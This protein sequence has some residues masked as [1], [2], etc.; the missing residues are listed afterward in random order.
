MSRSSFHLLL[1]LLFF[2]ARFTAWAQSPDTQQAQLRERTLLATN[3]ARAHAASGNWAEAISTLQNAINSLS[4]SNS[5]TAA[6]RHYLYF[7]MGY[8]YEHQPDADAATL[9]LAAQAYA[10]ALSNKPDDVKTLNNLI[11]VSRAIGDNLSALTY[12]DHIIRLDSSSAYQWHLVA[13]DIYRSEGRQD[14]AWKEYKKAIDLNPTNRTAAQ[15]IVD[16]YETGPADDQKLLEQCKEFRQSGM[17]EMARIGLEEILRKNCDTWSSDPQY[18]EDALLEWAGVLIENRW[19]RRDIFDGI[20]AMKC[21]SR[22]LEDLQRS[23]RDGWYKVGFAPSQ[24]SWWLENERRAFYYLAMQKSWADYLLTTGRQREAMEL[25]E[26]AWAPLNRIQD[27]SREIYGRNGVVLIDLLTQLARVYTNKTLDP[28]GMKFREMESRLFEQKGAAISADDLPA[29]EKF[30]TILGYI[31][32][33]RKQW[34]NGARGAKFQLEHAIRAAKMAA[35][36]DPT[37]SKPIPHLYHYLG[38]TYMNIG[39]P[40]E[41]TNAYLDAAIGYLETDNLRLA[42]QMVKTF[43]SI[44]VM[45]PVTQAKATSVRTL[46]AARSQIKQLDVESFEPDKG[47]YFRAQATYTW[48]DNPNG[49]EGIPDDVLKRQRFKALSDLSEQ[50]DNVGAT[51]VSQALKQRALTSLQEV[52]VL[53]SPQDVVRLNKVKNTSQL[54]EYNEVGKHPNVN[55]DPKNEVYVPTEGRDY[56]KVIY[57][58]EDIAERH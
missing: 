3:N 7:N 37:H 33:E 19:V 30:H 53:S 8:L 5:T 47:K 9:K 45:T 43:D 32:V 18:N 46:V 54:T 38:L 31:Y 23:I 58:K 34:Q 55:F 52:T 48:I 50:A 24:Q 20:A 1:G 2:L 40:G 56:K 27:R 25:Y 41:A 42:G 26:A 15:K 36:D 6:Y 13:G 22:P 14:Q 12:I 11:L 4:P 29:M 21:N 28:N 44:G 16:L 51:D 10:Q 49:L 39:N 17:A 57:F 35:Q